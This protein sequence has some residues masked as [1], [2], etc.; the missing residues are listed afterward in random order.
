MVLGK[1][2]ASDFSPTGGQKVKVAG[3]VTR[4]GKPLAGQKV[5]VKYRKV[6]AKWKTKRVTTD[7]K[8][9]YS[10]TVKSNRAFQA[11]AKFGN[12]TSKR[13]L[14][15]PTAKV[16]LTTERGSVSVK[17]VGYAK[18]APKVRIQ[19]K[20]DGRWVTVAKGRAFRDITIKVRNGTKLRAVS[21][22]TRWVKSGKS[23]T[24]RFA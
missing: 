5:T 7:A 16:T 14:V 3:T 2:S 11:Y 23:K 18:K 17:T 20:R 8:G 15:R 1:L 4:D 13:V 22:R 10:V 24:V 19:A 21:E 12:Q 6:K 9:R